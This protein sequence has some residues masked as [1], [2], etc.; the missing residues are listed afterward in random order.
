MFK[1]NREEKEKMISDIQAF[2][3]HER[4]EELSR[5]AAE[6]ILDF[7]KETIAPHYYNAGINESQKMIVERMMGIEEDLQSLKRPIR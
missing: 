7:F 6:S 3:L 1:I 4:D 2:F 5:F